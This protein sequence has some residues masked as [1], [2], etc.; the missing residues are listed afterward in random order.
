MYQYIKK[1]EP[2]TEI[3][4]FL[5]EGKQHGLEDLI[6]QIKEENT[7]YD[8]VIM[9]DASS[10]DFIYHEE[11]K[12]MGT[13]V[14]VLDHHI[15]ETEISTN[16]VIINNQ[17]SEKYKNKELTGA[18]VAWQFC[19]Y[20][21]SITNNNNAIYFTDLAALGIVGD[22]GGLNEIENQAIIRYG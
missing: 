15:L 17:S 14:L 5:H 9:P 20:V 7:K 2:L 4:Y 21:D 16:A 11:L 6:N 19:R 10:N 18:G 8:L 13:P 1:L 22:M 12:E 3:K